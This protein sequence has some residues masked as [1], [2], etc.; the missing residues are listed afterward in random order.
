M[1]IFGF[2]FVRLRI[3]KRSAN[4]KCRDIFYPLTTKRPVNPIT[5]SLRPSPFLP[6]WSCQIVTRDFHEHSVS[7]CSSK[8]FEIGMWGH[9][10]RVLQSNFWNGGLAESSEE[11]KEFQRYHYEN[12][13]KARWRLMELPQR[14]LSGVHRVKFP[15]FQPLDERSERCKDTCF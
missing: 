6:Y 12:L 3:F 15:L 5:T 10:W 14:S 7:H 1:G 2:C 13:C 8:F 11:Q 4:L 9:F